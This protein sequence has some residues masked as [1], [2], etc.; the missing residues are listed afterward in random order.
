[1]TQALNFAPAHWDSSTQLVAIV[2]A[3]HVG[4]NNECWPS[5]S[6]IRAR[7]RLDRRTIQRAIAQ[8]ENE[9]VLTRTARFDGRRQT[10]N[11][12]VW[13]MLLGTAFNPVDN[14]VD[15]PVHGVVDK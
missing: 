12:Y 10:S 14:S 11:L 4:G 3:D 15:N 13:T 2:I 9:S 6:S 1:M 7:T 5:T 8:L